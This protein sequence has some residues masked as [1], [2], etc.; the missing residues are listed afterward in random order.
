MN[1]T[2][3][4]T[5]LIP[6]LENFQALVRN[7]KLWISIPSVSFGV[8]VAMWYIQSIDYSSRRFP[9]RTIGRAIFY[10]IDPAKR[11]DVYFIS[12]LIFVLVFFFATVLLSLFNKTIHQKNIERHFKSD[13][14]VLLELSL[15]LLVNLALAVRNFNNNI[16]AI[17]ILL[18]AVFALISFSVLK[19]IWLLRDPENTS[20]IIISKPEFTFFAIFTPFPLLYFY[21]SFLGNVIN[22]FTPINGVIYALLFLLFVISM[23]YLPRKYLDSKRIALSL[24]PL[25]F[26][27]V[28]III[29]NELQYTLKKFIV[30]AP[31][32]IAQLLSS[33]LI[34]AGIFI[35]LFSKNN[36]KTNASKI[37]SNVLF[38]VTL[39]TLAAYSYHQ[40]LYVATDYEM[41]L[42]NIITPIQQLF[43][44]GKIPLLDYWGAQHLP[45]GGILYVLFNGLNQLEPI[46]WFNLFDKAIIIFAVYFILK[47][48]FPPRFVFLFC[49]FL[50]ILSLFSEYYVM[51]LLPI[52]YMKTFINN[53][54]LKNYI[55]FS[56][57]ILL[58]FVQMATTGKISVISGI[59]LLAVTCT[60]K[61]DIFK[62]IK[63]LVIVFGIPA[64]AYCI[65]TIIR[66]D[67]V[68]DKV[69]LIRAFSNLDYN[70]GAFPY[71]VLDSTPLWQII[72]TYGFPPLLALMII[73]YIFTRSTKSYRD[74]AVLFI[75]AAT[76]IE[77]LRSLAGH[78]LAEGFGL[79]FGLLLLLFFI[80]YM[81]N[82]RKIFKYISFFILT[83]FCILFMANGSKLI[84]GIKNFEFKKYG[85]E[86]SRYVA[87]KEY[88]PEN[89]IYFMK[90][91]LK[92]DQTY[93]DMAHRHLLYALTQR[94]APFFHH[95]IQ[96]IYP[97]PAQLV[98]IK[99]FEKKYKE[100]KIPIVIFADQ[101]G[102]SVT[103]LPSAFHVYKLSESIIY[104]YYKPWIIVDGY[105][106]WL[107]NN[108][109]ISISEA[110]HNKFAFQKDDGIPQSFHLVR[111]PFIWATYD[112]KIHK[113]K[114]KTLEDLG[115]NIVVANA[116]IIGFDGDIDKTDGNYVYLK[117]RSDGPNEE[118]MGL[119]YAGENGFLLNIF[120]GTHEYLIRISSQ[121]DWMT[122]N[123][124]E[125][126]IETSNPMIIEQI[127][128]LRGD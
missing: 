28:S 56:I 33:I 117:V 118:I 45:I 7:I 39:T 40:Q 14:T 30:I 21:Q 112:K 2:K 19:F 104:K 67:N 102:T 53:K 97:E 9:D 114:L 110:D 75:A 124:N 46:V 54:K 48:I 108:S 109:D 29:A 3:I 6:L 60:S 66:G 88:L 24:I 44:Y 81:K 15:L 90:N 1:P 127:S 113:N 94:E 76:L 70:M 119:S 85:A 95:D 84:E 34:I 35:Y 10:G 61:D 62:A 8:A 13:K 59:I 32:S 73:I 116:V 42:G 52:A 50:P 47:T 106:L 41:H 125:F 87:N 82:I 26:I 31:E 107:A 122:K 55:I 99:Q 91:Y 36:V 79:D 49:L 105:Q 57:L 111:L 71:I 25:S 23:R 96:C 18:F 11:Q 65:L 22:I 120:S 115:R 43:E 63:S 27:P 86:E 68:I 51:A 92:K 123:I 12:M 78:P 121:Y 77:K 4:K 16:K 72:L 83:G 5:S 126:L 80:F 93:F 69:T 58:P 103:H 98:Y 100:G 74:Y 64:F 17:V 128:I 38:P 89:L 20:L 101:Y 37:I